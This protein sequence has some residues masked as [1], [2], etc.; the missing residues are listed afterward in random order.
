M[1]NSNYIINGI[2]L[3]AVIVLFILQFTGKGN[4]ANSPETALSGSDS[5]GF[6]LPLA[7]VR[8]DSLY[9]NYNFYKDLSDEIMKK[10]EDKRLVI[11][12]KEDKWRK[13]ILDYQEKVEKN[14]FYSREMAQAAQNRLATEQQDLENYAAQVEQE[15]AL[16][17]LRMSKQLQDTIKTALK[18]YNTPKKYEIIFSDADTDN[19]LYADDI[20]DITIEVTEFLNA[21][22]VPEKK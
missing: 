3:A 12:Q 19:I 17:R 6:H 21:R 13:N 16:D 9:L 22:Y 4:G 14:V 11:K 15:M 20:Y 10:V 18:Q 2:L 7:Y 8:T 1:K 5:T